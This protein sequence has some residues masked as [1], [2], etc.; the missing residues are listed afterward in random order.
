MASDHDPEGRC[1][2]DNPCMKCKAAYWR[3]RT[4]GT[5][6]KYTYG[7]ETFHGPTGAEMGRREAAM[8]RANGGDPVPIS[9]RAE[10]I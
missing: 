7:R 9:T 3:E 10:L 4:T 1:A 6:I 5:P 8:L 2:T